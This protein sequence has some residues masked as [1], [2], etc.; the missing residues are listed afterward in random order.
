MYATTGKYGTGQQL[1]RQLIRQ[2][3]TGAVSATR[4]LPEEAAVIEIAHDLRRLICPELWL[5]CAEDSVESAA[6]RCFSRVEHRLRKQIEIGVRHSQLKNL[7]LHSSASVEIEDVATELTSRFLGLLPQLQK[8]LQDD[9]QAA[10]D[11]D[12]AA[13]SREEIIISYPGI[14][15]VLVYRMAHALLKL[16][17]PYL[18]RILTEWAHRETGID[19]HPGAQIG[20]RFFIDHGTGVVIGETCVIGSSVTLY[21]GVTLGAWSFPRDEDGRLIRGMQR[22][23]TLEDN[24]T[25]YSNATILGG[26]TVVGAGSQVGSSVTLSRSVPANTIVTIEDPSLQFREAV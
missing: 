4:P 20:P 6:R 18:P 22:H 23:P 8:L 7:R 1:V 17:V 10:F 25:I 11:R 5:S 21:Q 2:D 14:H 24:V 15:A 19:I 26:R 16:K 12:P 3:V 13:T 9:I